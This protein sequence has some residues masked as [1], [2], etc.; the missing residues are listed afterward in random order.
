MEGSEERGSGG[1]S[2]FGVRRGERNAESDLQKA[3]LG[4]TRACCCISPPAPLF[5]ALSSSRALDFCRFVSLSLVSLFSLSLSLFLFLRSSPF[6][7]HRS[8]IRSSSFSFSSTVKHSV[9]ADTEGKNYI[10]SVKYHEDFRSIYLKSERCAEAFNEKVQKKTR[11][12]NWNSLGLLTI[13]FVDTSILTLKGMAVRSEWRS[14]A[15]IADRNKVRRQN[16]RE[17]GRRLRLFPSLFNYSV[18]PYTGFFSMH[19]PSVFILSPPSRFLLLLSHPSLTYL[20]AFWLSRFWA[21]RRAS[22]TKNGTT[23]TDL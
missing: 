20:R 19:P 4:N 3:E 21:R 15:L 7:T 8:P 6:L 11:P 17:G 10:D 13:D 14:A 5:L 1:D 23:T 12:S 22:A 2:W 16:E 18:F 9:K